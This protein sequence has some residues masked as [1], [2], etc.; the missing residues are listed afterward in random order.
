V[1]GFFAAPAASRRAPSTA[2]PR[3]RQ[4]PAATPSHAPSGPDTA[5]GA[6]AARYTV[7]G[8]GFDEGFAPIQSAA[9]VKR[10]P[11]RT[12]PEPARNS[13]SRIKPIERPEDHPSRDGDG[14]RRVKESMGVAARK[15][16]RADD[17]ASGYGG[18]ERNHPRP[19]TCRGLIALDW[20]LHPVDRRVGR[21]LAFTGES[22]DLVLNASRNPLGFGLAAAAN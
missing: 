5:L 21:L 17:E 3:A 20:R 13:E 18:G 16:D 2:S 6:N 10:R 12:I 8:S 22:L 15:A 4:A 9:D 1:T 7:S 19:A 11:T 14:D